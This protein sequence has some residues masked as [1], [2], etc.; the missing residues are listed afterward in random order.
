VRFVLATDDF[1]YAGRPRPNFPIILGN[2]YIPAYP[3]Q[4]FLLWYLLDR[5]R[6]YSELTC[7]K[8]GRDIFD[9]A[10]FLQ[11]NERH[12]DEQVDAPGR[13]VVAAYRDWC[14][15][16][17]G[18]QA[19]TTNARIRLIATMYE[20]A[21]QRGLIKTNPISYS[22]RNRL[23][24][25]ASTQSL[26]EL[27]SERVDLTVAE[28]DVPAEFLTQE[29]LDLVRPHIPTQTQRLLFNLMVHV[30]LRSV[31]ARTFPM[32]YVFNPERRPDCSPDRLIRVR[33]SPRDMKLKFNKP[34][35]VDVPY[36]LMRDMYAYTLYERNRWLARSGLHTVKSL[37]LTVTGRSF[38]KDAVCRCFSRISE[39]S[40][41]RVTAHMLRHSYAI[42]T[43]M[44]LR[45]DSR[46]HGEPLLYI[47]DR[48]GHENVETTA[49]YL[50]QCDRLEATL[51]LA[52]NDE[53]D[54]IFAGAG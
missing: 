32:A 16:E 27:S 11:V 45:R 9:F 40:R 35:D 41:L 18:N 2:D 10:Q 20:W 28:W 42:L 48:L 52:I 3:Y 14:V 12:W 19:T 25:A 44:R 54:A 21:E 38:S 4:D 30:G 43:L 47:R 8:Y 53:Y 49:V 34:R 24:A 50:N 5:G 36:P 23:G 26:R 17:S 15:A 7:E 22:D 51:A 13:S 29:Q 31:E 33:L 46:F 39:A 1:M 6:K 37:L